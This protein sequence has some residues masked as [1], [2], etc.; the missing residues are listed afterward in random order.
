M[1]PWG[2]SSG[3]QRIDDE[4]PRGNAALHPDWPEGRF[5]VSGMFWFDQVIL[6]FLQAA[7]QGFGCR[8]GIETVYGAP[9]VR[10]S[11]ERHTADDFRPADLS[12]R[13][14]GLHSRGIG[15]FL[16]FT[17]HLL[18]AGDLDD[19]NGNLLLE[20]IARRPN[21]NGVIVSSE[22]LSKYIAGRYSSLRQVASVSKV[23]VEGGRGNASYYKELGKR[24][25]RYVVHADDRDDP[26]LLDQ[27]DR[28][29]AEIILNE[30]CLR[31]CSME[32]SQ[33]GAVARVYKGLGDHPP[34]AA[35][36]PGDALR[37]R[38][39]A[40]QELAPLLAVCPAE[41]LN[42]QIGK[43]Q[44]NDNLTRNE[45]KSLYDM[46]FRCFRIKGRDDNAF[47]FAYDLTR[48]TLEPGFAAPL[49][50]KKLCP[51]ICQSFPAG[52]AHAR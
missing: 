19:A 40:E 36:A 18:E 41:R 17:N 43:R 2:P 6:F 47:C 14:D 16:T 50:Y 30:D 11:G 33:Y 46:G 51:V 10:W 37:L 29:K 52:Q 28:T 23:V 42:R 4:F 8:V 15:C 7:E 27:L 31:G 22:L 5:A 48:Y 21:L 9:F 13:L 45:L 38:R 26:R 1:S 32:A 44:R 39:L 49:V 35:A 20:T 3:S 12:A 25:Y 24:F 34:E